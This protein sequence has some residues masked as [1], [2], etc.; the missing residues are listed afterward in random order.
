MTKIMTLCVV[1]KVVELV[2]KNPKVISNQYQVVFII[3]LLSASKVWKWFILTPQLCPA[4]WACSFDVS[5]ALVQIW[6]SS[7]SEEI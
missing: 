7:E 6:F 2:A 3:K 1:L 4:W 5:H